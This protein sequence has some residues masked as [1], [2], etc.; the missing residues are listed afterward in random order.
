MES[1]DILHAKILQTCACMLAFTTWQSDVNWI[2][3]VYH[4]KTGLFSHT[5]KKL[6]LQEDYQNENDQISWLLWP[7]SYFL[8]S[9]KV[10]DF[11][12]F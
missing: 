2:N 11:P 8:K 10:P 7:K 4:S 1:S 6:E 12:G 5:E 3:A 9:L